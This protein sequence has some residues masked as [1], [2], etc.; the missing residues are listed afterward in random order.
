MILSSPVSIPPA[1]H[2]VGAIWVPPPSGSVTGGLLPGDHSAA[3]QIPGANFLYATPI[4]LPSPT[5]VDAIVL[6]IAVAD[7]VNS[8]RVG[9]YNDD[10]RLTPGTL[11][12]DAGAW[13][14]TPAG[15]TT[16]TLSAA[17]VLHGIYWLAIV[18]NSAT[19]SLAATSQTGGVL[20]V[21]SLTSG[22]NI[23]AIFYGYVAHAFAA[24]P[25]PFGTALFDDPTFGPMR[26]QLRVSA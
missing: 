12:E 20:V 17:R 8:A 5:T 6:D 9:I 4:I 22:G 24:L 19:L 13:T 21:R 11:V 15:I 18:T 2:A 23:D 3:A 10:G 16:R 14:P 1:V 25:N 7:A 26:L